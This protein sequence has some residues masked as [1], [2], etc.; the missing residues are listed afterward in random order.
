MATYVGQNYGA[1]REDRIKQG[2]NKCTLIIL[3]LTLVVVA[4]V[5]IFARPIAGIF[6]DSSAD[7]ALRE[8]VV[9]Y[10]KMYFLSLIHI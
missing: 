6:L 9:Y 5:L 8:N 1:M 4:I 3:G 10:T 7:D 2:V